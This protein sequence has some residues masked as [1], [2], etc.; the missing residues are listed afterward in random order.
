MKHLALIA[1]MPIACAPL[2]PEQRS[3]I[4]DNLLKDAVAGGLGYVTGGPA[5]AAA[6]ALTQFERNHTSA[7]QPV[8]NIFA[9]KNR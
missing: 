8:P 7:K 6:G 9:Q 5:G 2:N 4:R 1:L 3:Q